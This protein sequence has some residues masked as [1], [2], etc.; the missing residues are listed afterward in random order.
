MLTRTICDDDPQ[1]QN[2]AWEKPSSDCFVSAFFEMEH[3]LKVSQHLVSQ[4]VVSGHFV[5]LNYITEKS[6]VEYEQQ[7]ETHNFFVWACP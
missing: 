6:S 3:N 7:L 2:F 5:Q 1:R 4:T